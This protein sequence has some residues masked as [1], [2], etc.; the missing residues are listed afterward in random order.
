MRVVDPEAASAEGAEVPLHLADGYL[1]GPALIIEPRVVDGEVL[2]AFYFQG[3]RVGPEVDGVA[4]SPGG[5]AADGAVAGLIRVRGLR[6]DPEMDC[7]AVAG[8]FEE[9]SRLPSEA[10]PAVDLHPLRIERDID[11]A[12]LHFDLVFG[13]GLYGGQAFRGACL[14]VELRAVQRARH[15]RVVELALAQVGELVGADVLEGVE[16]AFHVAQGDEA[17]LDQVLFDLPRANLINGAQRVE[18]GHYAARSSKP[19]PILPSIA[20]SSLSFKPF[21]GIL[22]VISPKNPKTTSFSASR[23][24]MPRLM[25]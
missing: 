23:R 15:H 9:Q 19:S 3:V 20:R 12:V 7:A 8:A 6:F 1:I 2:R 11:V 25:R 24:G 16:L 18:V 21:K 4:A 14:H 5:L 17:V 13:D 22:L 10:S